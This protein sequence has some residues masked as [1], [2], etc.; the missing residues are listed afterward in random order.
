MISF[1]R[2]ALA[3]RFTTECNHYQNWSQFSTYCG[4][5]FQFTV[6]VDEKGFTV[7]EASGVFMCKGSTFVEYAQFLKDNGWLNSGFDV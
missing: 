5:D 4:R 3:G 7:K 1:M 2:Q 6:T